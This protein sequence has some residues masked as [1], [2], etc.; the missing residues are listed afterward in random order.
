MVGAVLLT[1]AACAQDPAT[2][3]QRYL[4]RGVQYLAQGKHNEAI[5]ELKNALQIDPRFVPALHA[6]G[7][8]RLLAES[9]R[10]AE[11]VTH[12]QA[13]LR[14]Q[15][16]HVPAALLLASLLARAQQLDQAITVLEP[17][18]QGGAPTPGSS[19]T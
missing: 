3:K 4:D 15:P 12:L 8:A 13:L 17:I 16:R 5:I 9:R 19:S 18:V 2:K 11:A 14:S 1:L 7:L 6:L 10:E